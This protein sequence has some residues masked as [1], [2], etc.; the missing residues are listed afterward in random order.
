M[1]DAM[2][3][4]LKYAAAAAFG[5]L[6]LAAFAFVGRI[7]WS[8]G[9]SE[10]YAPKQA[11]EAAENALS[12]YGFELQ[13]GDAVEAAWQDQHWM[14]AKVLMHLSLTP[15]R[16]E[17]LRKAMLA[18]D[19]GEWSGWKTSVE[20]LGPGCAPGSPLCPGQEP[21]SAP[22]RPAWWKPGSL[23]DVEELQLTTSHPQGGGVRGLRVILSVPEGT[24]LLE[25][26]KT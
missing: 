18:A 11:R 17:A 4:F 19:G 13:P 8:V 6:A 7:W 15:E 26:W 20:H 24:V 9:A 12:R 14:D 22:K 3:R 5:V 21:P 1:V 10:D 25:L 2:L 23:R 16:A